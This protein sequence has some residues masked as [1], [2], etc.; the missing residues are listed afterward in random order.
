MCQQLR[1]KEDIAI[2]VRVKAEQRIEMTDYQKYIAEGN[3]KAGVS[4]GNGGVCGLRSE[5]RQTEAL[6]RC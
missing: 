3:D 6:C 2:K 5:G 4:G 1:N